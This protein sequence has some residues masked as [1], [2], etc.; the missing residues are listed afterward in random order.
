M[1]QGISQSLTDGSQ[2]DFFPKGRLFH[3][4]LSWGFL[5]LPFKLLALTNFGE[6]ILDLM[7]KCSDPVSPFLYFYTEVPMLLTLLLLN[8]M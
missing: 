4:C 5:Q 3:N 7:E 8:A 2:G 6:R 1:L